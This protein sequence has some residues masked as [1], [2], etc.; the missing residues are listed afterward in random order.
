MKTQ[1]SVQTNSKRSIPVRSTESSG[2]DAYRAIED[3]QVKNKLPISG[4]PKQKLNAL[5]DI[6][7]GYQAS[8]ND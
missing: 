5:L 4:Q 1:K 8:L 6:L 2:P 3:Y 7:S